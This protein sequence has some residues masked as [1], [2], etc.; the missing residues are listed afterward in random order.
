[1]SELAAWLPLLR[2]EAPLIVSMPHTGT[3]MPPSIES[4]FRSGWLAQKDADWWI[5][6]LYDFAYELGATVIRTTVCRTV[7]DVNRDPS[8]RSLYPGQNTT[9]LCPTTTFDGEA[10]YAEG[11]QPDA[12]EIAARRQSFFD[13]YHQTLQAEIARLLL[14]H[15]K[16]VLYE[17][18]SIRSRIPRL[19]KGELP[20]VNIGTNSGASCNSAL[21]RAIAALIAESQFTHVTNGRFKGGYTTR[22]YGNP[23]EGVHA[24]QLELAM[25]GYLDEP[26]SPSAAN[27]PAPYD[28]SRALALRRV[29]RRILETCLEFASQP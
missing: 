24:I 21:T 27:W 7:I 2:N 20:H 22:H 4:Q 5:E 9:E 15:R 26:V 3:E 12:T 25:R 13:P 18:H 28:P 17:A 1:M 11:R 29:L 10:L 14:R 16:I 19:F 23:D 8:G 6:R